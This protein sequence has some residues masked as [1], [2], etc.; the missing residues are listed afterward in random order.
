MKKL[1]RSGLPKDDIMIKLKD[2]FP[3]TK[4]TV[5]EKIVE[6]K[7]N[8]EYRLVQKI[9]RSNLFTNMEEKGTT[10]YIDDPFHP[11]IKRIE[12]THGNL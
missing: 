12:K 4:E 11:E 8:G 7:D 3:E 1:I 6:E 2:K 5:I 9:M 10:V